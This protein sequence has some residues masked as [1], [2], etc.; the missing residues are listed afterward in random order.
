[1]QRRI[2][3][4]TYALMMLALMLTSCDWVSSAFQEDSN[5]LHDIERFDILQN[6]YGAS[7]SFSVIQHMNTDFP[8]ETKVLIEDVLS[9]GAVTD[10]DVNDKL[11][12]CLADTSMLVLMADGEERFGNMEKLNQ[13]FYKAFENLSE[14]LPELPMPRIYAQYSALNQSVVVA[15]SLIG[16]SV[17]KY[18]GTDYP[19]YRKYFYDYQ[20]ESMIPERI[21]PDCVYFYLRYYYPFPNSAEGSLI[22]HVIHN[23]V[24][25]WIAAK[26]LKMNDV[27]DML[28]MPKQERKWLKN[29]EQKI[30]TL[31]DN[32][33][34][35]NS[36]DPQLIRTL[37]APAP[38]TPELG[39]DSPDM[40]GVW[41]GY[42]IVDKYMKQHSKT[43][44]K[45][46]L[47]KKLEELLP[48]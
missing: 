48:R 27:E 44:V 2:S 1:M 30:W 7:G 5:K 38:F 18:M 22:E 39:E 6:E 24:L 31:L 32:P 29:N 10:A 11:Y 23:G 21:V 4:Y 47:D 15:D 14:T 37:L 42:H 13:Q 34:I 19:P 20:I 9:L 17:D 43:T 8:R 41:A 3:L 12:H 25:N 26:A 35:R 40:L 45:E 33:V 28:C 46:L 36:K 16:F